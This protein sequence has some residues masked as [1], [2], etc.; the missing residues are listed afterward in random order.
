[1]NSV[2]FLRLMLKLE[3]KNGNFNLQQT[4]LMY[5]LLQQSQ[6]ELYF[7][8]VMKTIFTQLMLQLE[9]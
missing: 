6:M 2:G 7:W 1:M 8:V 9:H 4:T 3:R 5:N